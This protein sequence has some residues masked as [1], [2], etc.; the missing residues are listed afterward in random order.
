[1]NWYVI[2]TKPRQEERALINLNNQGY[3]CYLPRRLKQVL[4]RNELATEQEALFPRYM[5]INL[6][7][8]LTGKSWAPIRSTLGVSRILTFG[9][10]PARVDEKTIAAM[11]ARES[12]YPEDAIPLFQPGDKV[13]VMEGPFAGIEAVYQMNDGEARVMVLIDLLSRQTRLTL[14]AKSLRVA[15]SSHRFSEHY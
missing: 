2:H 5:F 11:Q 14:P 7:V 8:S 3:D 6:D 10:E 13:R 15:Q 4:R 9:T 1:M 12:Q